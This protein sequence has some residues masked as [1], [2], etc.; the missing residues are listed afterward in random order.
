MSAPRGWRIELT[1]GT[2]ARNIKQQTKQPDLNRANG[3]IA[4]CNTRS[5]EMLCKQYRR[6]GLCTQQM[7]EG[8]AMLGEA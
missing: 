4:I 8:V 2:V 5:R 6:F 1:T 3:L 7:H